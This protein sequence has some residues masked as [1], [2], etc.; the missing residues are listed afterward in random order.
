MKT[1]CVA[2]PNLVSCPESS[3]INSTGSINENRT[4]QGLKPSNF[5]LFT[6]R[7]KPCPDTKPESIFKAS[8]GITLE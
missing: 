2:L 6:A 4:P 3:L 5:Q 7:L 1:N 8:R